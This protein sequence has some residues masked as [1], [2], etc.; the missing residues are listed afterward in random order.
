MSQNAD[1]ISDLANKVPAP[2]DAMMAAAPSTD[3][4]KISIFLG[5][6]VLMVTFEGM[7]IVG[8]QMVPLSSGAGVLYVFCAPLYWGLL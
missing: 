2:S 3:A 8:I 4:S 1:F 5:G 6:Q 7:G